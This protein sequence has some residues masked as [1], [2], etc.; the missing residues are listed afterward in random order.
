MK[1]GRN[2]VEMVVAKLPAPDKLMKGKSGARVAS[3]GDDEE[4]GDIGA[5]SAVQDF[6][7]AIGVKVDPD[8]LPD[9]VAAFKDLVHICMHAEDDEEEADDKP[10]DDEE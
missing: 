7:K 2:V 3:Y 4:E 1:K 10:D 8:K 9:A 5:E 6:C